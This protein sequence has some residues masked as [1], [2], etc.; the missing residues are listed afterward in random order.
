MPCNMLRPLRAYLP[1]SN[2]LCRHCHLLIILSLTCCAVVRGGDVMYPHQRML[3]NTQRASWQT[4]ET[5]SAASEAAGGPLSGRLLRFSR[6]FSDR[7]KSSILL[8]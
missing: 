4:A 7:R 3:T 8:N 1:L 5:G 2:S 6:S